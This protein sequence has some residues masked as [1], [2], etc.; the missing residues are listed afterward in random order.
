MAK[1]P[2]RLMDAD[3]SR[4]VLAVRETAAAPFFLRALGLSRPWV[5]RVLQDGLLICEGV[6]VTLTDELDGGDV[7]ELALEV[8]D[9]EWPSCQ[10]AAV[11]Y[12]DPFVIAV[13]KPQGLIV[14]DDGTDQETLTERV[15]AHLA[16][17]GRIREAQCIQ[18]LDRDT[19][20]VVLFSL[21]PEFQGVLDQELAERTMAKE[22]LAVVQGRFPDGVKTIEAAI[23]RDRHRADRMHVGSGRPAVTRV[24]TV[25]RT[26]VKGQPLTLVAV[27]IETGRRHQIR[28]H[29]AWAGFPVLGD[30][31]YGGKAWDDGL[32]LH[33]AR[34]TF[35]HPLKGSKVVVEAPY[36]A[37]FSALFEEPAPE[38]SSIPKSH[39]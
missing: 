6:P 16:L 22:Y 30:T 24:R 29:L 25:A 36:P 7:V 10:P 18:R 12:E 35:V 2:W 26:K 1:R 13:D 39:G 3:D 38:P 19:T 28:A 17:E 31:L 20:G 37:R 9:P 32:M 33:C 11:L 27:S 21:T 15:Q 23:G 5:N 8:A 14:H 34:E 4:V